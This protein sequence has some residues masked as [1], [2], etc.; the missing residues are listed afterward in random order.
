M[1][2]NFI[3]ARLELSEYANR[4]LAVIK[5]KYGLNDKSEALN[6]MAEIFGG[7][8]V[9]KQANENYVKKVISIANSHSKKYGNRKMSLQELNKLCEE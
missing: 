6:K 5:A 4:V 8:F 3:S 2:Q 1:E 7:D 9:E